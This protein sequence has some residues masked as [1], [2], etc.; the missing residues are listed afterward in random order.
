MPSPASR[1]GEQQV[2]QPVIGA[3]A[4]QRAG[5]HDPLGTALQRFFDGKRAVGQVLGGREALARDVREAR[6]KCCIGG[7]EISDPDF[8][9]HAERPGMAHAAIGCN[10]PASGHKRQHP[11]VNR[12]RAA[13]QYRE[14]LVS[15]PTQ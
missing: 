12:K 6:N 8:R 2:H 14:G 7:I 10:H 9:L 4:L 3:L 15:S 11:V 5:H 13:Q 1:T